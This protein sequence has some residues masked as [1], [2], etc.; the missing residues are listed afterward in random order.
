[1]KNIFIRIL[2]LILVLT[3]S[4]VLAFLAGDVSNGIDFWNS[5]TLKSWS[6]IFGIQIVIF[7][8]SFIFKTEHYFDITGGLTFILILVLLVDSTISNHGLFSS[9]KLIPLFLISL[10]AVRLSTFLFLR[11]K[12]TGK[13][14]RFDE[15]KKKFFKIYGSMDYS[16]FLGFHVFT[17]SNSYGWF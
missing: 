12:R 13:D 15:I 5:I 14:I 11:V 3:S 17:S 4:F 7:L 10:W 6:L 8:P 2:F 9:P 1:M 16:R